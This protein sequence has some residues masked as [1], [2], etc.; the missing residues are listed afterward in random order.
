MPSDQNDNMS[1]MPGHYDTHCGSQ[2]ASPDCPPL[3]PILFPLHCQPPLEWARWTPHIHN[4]RKFKNNIELK[5]H[6]SCTGPLVIIEGTL[7]ASH[8]F[9][10]SY[11]QMLK[12]H[13]KML[14]FR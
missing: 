3:S 14:Q 8:T 1:K 10:V 6:N 9:S 7:R 5:L 4:L 13:I 2:P 11:F 12:Y